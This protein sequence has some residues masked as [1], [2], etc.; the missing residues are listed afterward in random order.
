M[1]EAVL[2]AHG[3]QTEQTKQ[4]QHALKSHRRSK[5]S[6]KKNPLNSMSKWK[7]GTTSVSNRIVNE[8]TPFLQDSQVGSGNAEQAD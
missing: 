2:S 3:L 8:L 1:R 7:S 4:N 6:K 5:N